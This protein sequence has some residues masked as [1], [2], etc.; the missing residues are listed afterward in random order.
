MVIQ[1]GQRTQFDK[2][3]SRSDQPLQPCFASASSSPR[4][5]LVKQD[6][7]L[8]DEATKALRVLV[9]E[10]DAMIATLLALLLKGM[11]H[12]VCAIEDTEQGA[13]A[14]AARLRP[15]LMI[16]DRCL[17]DGDGVSAVEEVCRSGF[18]PHVFLSGAPLGIESLQLG[19]VVLQKPFFD[20]DL[21]RAMERA[22]APLAAA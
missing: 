18:V 22:L 10:D 15:D 19:S 3:R 8:C 16:V 1:S 9:V 2:V 5:S 4:P 14:A 12:Q 20:G 7:A 11:G 17:I 21:R 6:R 13:V